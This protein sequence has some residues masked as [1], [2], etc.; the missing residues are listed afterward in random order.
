[1][2][3]G[4]PG[5]YRHVSRHYTLVV[6]MFKVINLKTPVPSDISKLFASTDD[7]YVRPLHFTIVL[8]MLVVRLWWYVGGQFR[9]PVFVR[10][11]NCRFLKTKWSS[12]VGPYTLQYTHREDDTIMISSSNSEFC[13]VC[14]SVHTL[15]RDDL[16]LYFRSLR[17]VSH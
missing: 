3:V 6:F 1:M 9:G 7:L 16:S 2:V 5:R 13:V 4:W 17:H 15:C 11:D 12:Q 8:G 10:F 14:D